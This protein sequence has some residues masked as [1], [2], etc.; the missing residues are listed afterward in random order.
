[1]QLQSIRVQKLITFSPQ[2]HAMVKQKAERLG[3]T[4]AEYLRML[5]A[6][7]VKK[8]VE[9]LYLLDQKTEEKV[10][11]AVKDFRDKNYTLIKNKK[12]L[13]THLANR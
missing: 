12:A 8:E 10:G 6:S 1:M 9:D 5:A 7:D 3:L 4:F 11:L 13:K 2:L